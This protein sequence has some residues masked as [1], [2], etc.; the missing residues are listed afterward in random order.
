M[1]EMIDNDWE[2]FGD[3]ADLEVPPLGRKIECRDA[4]SDTHLVLTFREVGEREY[5]E[6]ARLEHDRLCQGAERD[7][8]ERM[9]TMPEHVRHRF[10][11][12]GIRASLD[13]GFEEHQA[14]VAAMK[15]Q[16]PALLVQMTGLL[17]YPKRIEIRD[18]AVVLL[19][20]CTLRGNRSA[21]NGVALAF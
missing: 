13:R 21:H 15:L 4:Q 14:R 11:S 17:L 5:L 18:D 12:G 19:G 3:L 9:S 6:H 10:D 1:F 8:A 20:N 2:T 16:W 7:L